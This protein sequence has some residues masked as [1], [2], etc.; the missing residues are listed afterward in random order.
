MNARVWMGEGEPAG[1]DAS[2]TTEGLESVVDVLATNDAFKKAAVDLAAAKTKYA[3]LEIEDKASADLLLEQ[4]QTQEVKD[5]ITAFLQN[6]NKTADV[7]GIG[8]TN[9]ISMLKNE[10]GSFT[11]TLIKEDQTLKDLATV[12]LSATKLELKVGDVVIPLIEAPA[13]TPEIATTAG[14]DEPNDEQRSEFQQRIDELKAQG[15]GLMDQVDEALTQ[16][17]EI[18]GVILTMF[19]KDMD[20]LDGKMMY[21][22][23][24]SGLGWKNMDKLKEIQIEDFLDAEKGDK[25]ET[26]KELEKLGLSVAGAREKAVLTLLNVLTTARTELPGEATAGKTV[27]EYIE[28]CDLLDKRGDLK[29]PVKPTPE[30]EKEEPVPDPDKVATTDATGTAPANAPAVVAAATDGASTNS[31]TKS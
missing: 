28:K 11:F 8:V 25:A 31:A 18:F 19:G 1:S 13:D 7:M 12:T 23:L 9:S 15:S 10:D 22:M 21:Y 24:K 16:F 26:K 17:S 2:K 14:A 27:T 4:F 3:E 20:T 29:K 30:S 5:R 6:T